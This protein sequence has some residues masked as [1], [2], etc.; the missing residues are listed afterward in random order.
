MY[1]YIYIY[2]YYLLNFVMLCYNKNVAGTCMFDLPYIK[3]EAFVKTVYKQI[4]KYEGM[5]RKILRI[6][7]IIW[8]RT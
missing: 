3:R 2:A 5:M 6:V 7:G 8:F 4:A 1:I